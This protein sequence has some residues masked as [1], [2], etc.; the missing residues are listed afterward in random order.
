MGES[1][2]EDYNTVL[3]MKTYMLPQGINTINVIYFDE[4][5]VPR[6]CIE[7]KVDTI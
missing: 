3:Y 1:D 6:D 4:D 2:I 7:F 5:D